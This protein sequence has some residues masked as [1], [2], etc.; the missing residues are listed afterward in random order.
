VKNGNGNGNGTATEEIQIRNGNASLE[1]AI[2]SSHGTAKRL[3]INSRSGTFFG[4]PECHPEAPLVRGNGQGADHLERM[5]SAAWLERVSSPVIV[6]WMI[7]L[8]MQYPEMNF[9]ALIRLLRQVREAG[10]REILPL[11]IDTPRC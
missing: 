9:W 5:A 6:G 7:G 4:C 3:L 1:P 11:P 8:A 10:M 2:C